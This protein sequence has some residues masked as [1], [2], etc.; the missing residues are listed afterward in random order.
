MKKI[1]L[2]IIVI[3]AIITAS[4]LLTNQNQAKGK[5]SKN[6][7]NHNTPP[8][9]QIQKDITPVAD[10]KGLKFNIDAIEVNKDTNISYTITPIYDKGKIPKELKELK[11]LEIVSDVD[12][13]IKVDYQNKILTALKDINLTLKAK[14]GNIISNPQILN[15][16]WEVNGH[17]LPPEP[18][19]KVNNATLLGV[20]VNHNGV[21]DDVERTIYRWYSKKHP[22]YIA[23]AMEAAK[24]Y[25]MSLMGPDHYEEAHKLISDVIGCESYYTLF[26]DGYGEKL[27]I[28]R[29]E[30]PDGDGLL[31]QVLNTKARAKAYAEYDKSLSGKIYNGGWPSD[32]K[33]NCPESIKEVLK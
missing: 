5:Q 3:I 28:D 16:Y 9:A 32:Y 33:K 4:L 26:A 30:R 12:N 23:I 14:I 27:L 6:H 22:I 31:L 13:S 20:D 11:G 17:R 19:P 18:D 29:S 10:I 8:K 15:V 7:P 25:Q 1:T 2:S 21:R 24:S